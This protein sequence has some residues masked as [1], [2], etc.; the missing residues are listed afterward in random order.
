MCACLHLFQ[1]PFSFLFDLLC[2]WA[3]LLHIMGYL[4]EWD[5]EICGG[6]DED[7]GV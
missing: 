7:R 1:R 2:I 4:A 6:F 5:F 3:G